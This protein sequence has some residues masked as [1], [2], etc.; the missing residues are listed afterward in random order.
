MAVA[1]FDYGQWAILYPNLASSVTEPQA[2]ALFGQASLYCDNSE[3]SPVSDLTV[4]LAL[5]NLLVAHLAQL[6]FAAASGNALAGPVESAKEGSVEVKVKLP[7]ARGLEFWFLQTPYGQ[8]YWAATAAWRTMQ[9][10]PGPQP[11]FEAWQAGYG[12]GFAPWAY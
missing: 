5:L 7:D 6:N 12:Y 4:R 10:V 2:Q 1:V 11:V 8:Q 9:Y 3:C